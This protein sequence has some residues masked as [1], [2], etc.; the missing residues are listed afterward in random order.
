MSAPTIETERL[1]LRS[2][3]REDF[4][5]CAAMWA[6]PLVVRYIGGKPS[7]PQQTWSRLLAYLGHWRAMGYGY[8]A[9]DEKSTGKF[10]GEIGF[11]DFKREI[12]PSMQNVPELGFALVSD[13]HGKGYGTQA[14][15]AVLE[16]GDA[17]LPSRRTVCLVNEDNAA[18][19]RIVQKAGYTI[20]ERVTFNDSPVAFLERTL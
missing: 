18:S 15:R 19:L 12:A 3:R 17:N 1:R 4:A 7:T 8:W 9:I 16:W 5:D 6:D 20:F 11:A 13:A 10:V 2:H 14:V